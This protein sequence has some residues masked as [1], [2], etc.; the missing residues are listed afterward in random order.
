MINSRYTCY[1]LFDISDKGTRSEIRNW[2]TLIQVISL[3][4][5]P[6]INKFPQYIEDD[7]KNYKF[8]SLYTGLGRIW[9]F[10]FQ[11]EHDVFSVNDNPLANLIKDTE[12]IPLLDKHNIIHPPCCCILEGSACNIYY[13]YNE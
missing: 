5:Q 4:T 1:T 3:R 7:Y 6:F 11:I 12:M 2:N 8:G 10:E 13:V 9:T